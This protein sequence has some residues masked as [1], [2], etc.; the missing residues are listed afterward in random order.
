L[1]KF[2]EAKK[3]ADDLAEKF[4]EQDNIDGDNFFHPGNDC[5]NEGR[6]LNAILFYYVATV[7][8]YTKNDGNKVEDFEKCLWRTQLAVYEMLYN[9]KNYRDI[10]KKHILSLMREMCH[11]TR[12][13]KSIEEQQKILQE[14]CY[15]SYIHTVEQIAPK[16]R[17]SLASTE[18]KR[19][20][21]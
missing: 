7:L 21:M 18:P 4:I 13:L 11:K 5:R 9:K 3:V 10:V 19:L 20:V 12:G 17:P 2:K 14:Q 16:C 6:L 1:G 15:Q 8:Y